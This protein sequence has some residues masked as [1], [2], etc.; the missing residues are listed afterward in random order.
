MIDLHLHTTA[1]DGRCSPEGLVARAA[2]AGLTTIAVT[3]HDT[4]AATALVAELCGARGLRAVSGI[5][6][7]AIEE[8]RDVHVLGYFV[9]HTDVQLLVFLSGQRECRV[10][11]VRTIADLLASFD[12][13]ID[14]A[15]L[16]RSANARD[17]RSIGRPQIARAMFEAGYVDSIRDAFDSW[18][19]PGRPAFVVR[20][21]APPE[22]V[23]AV[24]H[25]AGG[26]A[27]LAHP[28]K[29]AID[30]EIP[31][32]CAAGLDAIEVYHWDHPPADRE[33]YLGMASDLQLLVTGGSDYHGDPTHGASLGVVALP[34]EAFEHLAS[35]A[36]AGGGVAA[37]G[38]TRAG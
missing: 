13:P 20:A 26:I 15:E 12:M 14:T 25:G 28:G 33:R 7:T 9:D 5:E 24:I 3:D 23:I 31:R 6:I 29:T 30:A 8:G 18:L 27:S 2:A 36:D 32:L 21:G 1:S 4:V 35:R 10:E 16:L 17:G 37:R 34:R 11:R 22:H 38:K 19:V